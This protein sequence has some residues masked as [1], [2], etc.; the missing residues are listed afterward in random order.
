MF[1]ARVAVPTGV[2]A[3]ALAFGD[4]VRADLVVHV[5]SKRMEGQLGLGALGLGATIFRLLFQ[6]VEPMIGSTAKEHHPVP[7]PCGG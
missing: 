6:Q 5:V 3:K 7:P 2:A 4:P 1:G